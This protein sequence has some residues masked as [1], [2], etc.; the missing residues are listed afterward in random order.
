M[1]SL[2]KKY[3]DEKQ[4]KTVDKSKEK[5]FDTLIPKPIVKSIAPLGKQTK[6]VSFL[7][8]KGSLH[9]I[10]QKEDT[11]TNLDFTEKD[12]DDFTEEQVNNFWN[13]Y[14]E[15]LKKQPVLHSILNTTQC[16]VEPNH[17]IFFKF[18]SNSA[19]DEFENLREDIFQK[20]KKAVNNYSINFKYEIKETTR[21]ILLTDKDKYEK[22][23]KENPLLKKLKNDFQLDF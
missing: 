9:T 2:T 19:Y 13:G 15:A 14:L 22:M 11:V 16:T 7:S 18:P 12:K 1:L 23:V 5:V 6:N 4:V 3:E 8:I 20:L 21:T 10:S 17:T